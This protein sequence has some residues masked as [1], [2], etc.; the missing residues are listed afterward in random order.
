MNKLRHIQNWVLP[1]IV[2]LTVAGCS[3]DFLQR[4][5]KDSIVDGSFYQTDEQ[6]LAGTALLYSK[7]WFDYNDKASYNIGD[8]RGGVAFS[9]YNDQDQVRFNTTANTP[10]NGF[11]WQAFF[12]VIGQSNTAIKN[13]NRYAGAEVSESVKRHAIAEARFMRALAYRYLVMNWG[14]VPIITDNEALLQQPTSIRRNTVESVWRFITSEMRAAANDLAETPIQTGRL[15]KASAEAM[16]ARF[17]LTRSGV[18]QSGSRNQDYLD[19]AKYF[20][21]KVIDSQQYSLL[22]DYAKLFTYPYDN[23]AESIFEL[24]WVYTSNEWGTQNSTPAYLAYSGDIANG[25]GWGGDKSATLWMLKKYQGLMVTGRTDDERLKSTF[26]LP[27]ASYPEISQNVTVDGKLTKQGLIFPFTGTDVN[28]A[29]IKKYVTGQNGDNG[30]QASQQHYGHDTYMMRYAEVLLIYVEAAIGNN[31]ESSDPLAITYFN[32]V[33][34]RAGLPEV[35]G[36]ISFEDV[37]NERILEFAMEGMSWYDLVSYHYYKP[38]AAADSVAA[39]YRGGFF[40]EPDQFPSPSKWTFT[41]TSWW[42]F[43]NVTETQAE[44]NFV[45]PIPATEAS[46]APNLL[47]EPVD[48]YAN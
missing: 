29:S 36:P 12:V 17:Y 38:Q 22:D 5:P 23:N 16:L 24:Q 35:A 11:S 34:T 7:C 39:Q 21:K 10:E 26:M 14:D 45:L 3:D 19:S 20:A 27:G 42:Q 25:D 2:L 9:A 31:T 32:Q 41:E 1:L 13:I 28:F 6:V 37:Y 15:T 33:H 8:F 43:K 30:Q 46:Q 18:G 48:Y 44:S 4:P 47:D 40:V